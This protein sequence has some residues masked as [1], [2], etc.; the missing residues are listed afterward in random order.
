MRL[1]RAIGRLACRLPRPDEP[2]PS[3][4]RS[5]GGARRE[6]RDCATRRRALCAGRRLGA[7]CTLH[8]GRSVPRVPLN[9]VPAG[10]IGLLGLRRC[11]LAGVGRTP[12]RPSRH[13]ALGILFPHE[14]T[15]SQVKLV[16]HHPRFVRDCDRLTGSG[17]SSG[18][19]TALE[20]IVHFSGTKMAEDAQLNSQYLPSPPVSAT[21]PKEIPPCPLPKA[22]GRK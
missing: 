5:L 15:V 21:I 11:V 18:L 7:T 9:A 16:D 3:Q 10:Q 4:A 20:L 14:G 2:G 8:E 17:I 19:N 1:F 13:R 22:G 6:H 12:R